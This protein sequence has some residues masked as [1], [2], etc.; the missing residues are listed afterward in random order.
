M[1]IRSRRIQATE[2]KDTTL[3][4]IQQNT[5]LMPH[6]WLFIIANLAWYGLA[7]SFSQYIWGLQQWGYLPFASWFFSLA[8][9]K[10]FSWGATD[11]VGKRV[12][13]IERLQGS[14]L[15]SDPEPESSWSVLTPLPNSVPSHQHR[16]AVLCLLKCLTSLVFIGKQKGDRRSW[17]YLSF[18]HCSHG[19][20][21]CCFD[22]I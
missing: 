1:H 18:S 11:R 12:A 4:T 17:C 10:P 22:C 7:Y 15:T 9:W 20:N 8:T 5:V 21:F 6:C 19:T 16:V 3:W 14:W 13:V 2:G